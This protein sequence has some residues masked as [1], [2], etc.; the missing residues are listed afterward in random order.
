MGAKECAWPRWSPDGKWILYFHQSLEG[1]MVSICSVDGSE[2][3]VLGVFS[4][5]I[6]I[7]AQ[8]S[9]DGKKVLLLM[10]GLELE[11][12]LCDLEQLGERQLLETGAPLF[13]SWGTDASSV[14]VHTVH[15]KGSQLIRHHLERSAPEV[16]SSKTG[17]FCV[18]REVSEGILFVE[19]QEGEAAL[20]V[21]NEENKTL[22]HHR[23]GFV[24]MSLSPD[25]RF[26]A[27]AGEEASLELLNIENGVV[28]LLAPAPV[29]SMWWSP[30]G[31]DIL[32]SKREKTSLCWFLINVHTQEHR[33]VREFWPTRDQLFALHF[34]EQFGM[35]Q[36]MID[37]SGEYILYGGHTGPKGKRGY[38]PRPKIFSY[39]IASQSTNVLG[40][41]VFPS[42]R[43]HG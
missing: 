42:L 19:N 3:K 33:P 5:E 1:L 15:E 23:K 2:E 12:W 13:F 34:F 39:H 28:T 30:N 29:Q 35:V 32:Y 37:R 26:C 10:Q 6:P 27:L 9:P 11:L 36:P 14:L 22:L 41:G 20:Y 43:P 8:W 25:E 40:E 16:L 7:F 17:L 18:P 24:S 38:S 21:Q 4:E 31:E